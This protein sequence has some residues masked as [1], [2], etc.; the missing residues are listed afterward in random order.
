MLRVVV[1]V[2]HPPPAAGSNREEADVGVRVGEG[3]EFGD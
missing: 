3:S 1:I 2:E